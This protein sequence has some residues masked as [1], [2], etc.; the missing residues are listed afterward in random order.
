MT[1]SV[2]AFGCEAG[3]HGPLTDRAP[4]R[5]A[6]VGGRDGGVLQP[7]EMRRIEK[8]RSDSFNFVLPMFVETSLFTPQHINT[9]QTL[10]KKIFHHVITYPNPTFPC[11]NHCCSH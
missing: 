4:C 10:R 8:Q 11:C 9:F 3:A 7:G 6:H 5:V 1:Y 2:A